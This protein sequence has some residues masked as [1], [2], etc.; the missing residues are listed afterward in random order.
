MATP[1]VNLQ[2]LRLDRGL[3]VRQAAEQIGVAAGT[4]AQAETGERQPHPGSALKI[5]V[6]YGLAVTEVW[7][8]QTAEPAEEAA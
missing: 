5:A 4:L 2:K 3:S 1:A 6:F 7:P 8:L